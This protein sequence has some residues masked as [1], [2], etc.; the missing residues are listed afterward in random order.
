MQ[1]KAR[2]VARGFGQREGIA[3]FDTFSPCPSVMSIC[4]LAALAC[5]LD[6]DLCH[7]DAEQAFVQSD[8][9]EVVYI[10]LPPGCGAL[11]GKVVR[12]RRSLFGLKQALRTWHCHLVR[13]MKALA[14]E[15]CE[16]DACV[17]SLVEDGA[18]SVVVV[19]HVDDIFAIGRKSRCDKFGDG[20]DAYIPITNLGELQWY[21][22]CRFERDRVSGTVKVFQQASVE[23]IV[24]KFGVTLGKPT[25]I[26]V[27]L[28]LD[29]FDQEEAE[30]E[31]PF[32]SLVGH[33]MW[34]ANQTRPGM[35]NAVRAVARY[36][37]SPKPVHWKVALHILQ[38]IRLTSGHGIT[39]QRGMGSV[40]DLELYVDSEFASRDT[41]RRSVP[42][43]VVM[44]A[45]ACVSFFLGRR[46]VSPF[47]LLRQSMLR[48]PRGSRR[49]FMVYLEFIFP[50]RDVGCTLV[51][52]DNVGVIHL[53][54]N[55]AT[56]PN[57]K[58]IDIRHHFIRERLA[59][60]E[61]KVVYVPSEEQHADFLTK[62]LHPGAFEVHRMFVMNIR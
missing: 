57:S 38:Y 56:T 44:C 62:S 8:L 27:G 49:R 13:G 30:V 12:L 2:L 53:A 26:V 24:A 36:S 14:F 23:K 22:G 55:P 42:E 60:G 15:Q 29:E 58:H 21:A 20:L 18:V 43:G 7:F 46:K 48:W 33:L 19:V 10:R 32:R 31:E 41:N 45:G 6:L 50:D 61:F 1:A 54:K 37:H 52:E 59:N 34:L 28:K 39:F 16:A 40:V 51:K 17:I 25:F 35:L 47:L 3:F 4:L 9:D 11:S 5:E